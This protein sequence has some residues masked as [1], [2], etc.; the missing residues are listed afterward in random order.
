MNK[1][2]ILK[3]KKSV[4]LCNM[5]AEDDVCKQCPYYK[6][7]DKLYGCIDRRYKDLIEILDWGILTIETLEGFLKGER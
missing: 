3:A 7:N 4:E 2:K 1:E 6:D 5:T